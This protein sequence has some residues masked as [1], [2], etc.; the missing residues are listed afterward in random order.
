MN[1]TFRLATKRVLLLTALAG[2]VSLAG[3]A[4]AD[5]SLGASTGRANID[6]STLQPAPLS[7]TVAGCYQLPL[8]QREFCASQVGW[9]QLAPSHVAINEQASAAAK[10]A[11]ARCKSLPYSDI[12]VC[13]AQAGYGEKVPRPTMLSARQKATVKAENAR[14]QA[15]AASCKRGPLSDLDTCLSLAGND[16]TLRSIG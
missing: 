9:S 13:E 12:F 6:L 16:A 3:I 4:S 8:S 10:A 2:G 11:M 1:D 5:Q 7:A 15:A 14:Y